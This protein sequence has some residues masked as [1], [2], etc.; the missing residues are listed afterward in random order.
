MRFELTE[1]QR[2]FAASLDRLLAAA[3]TPAVARAW[4]DGDHE[5]GLKLWDRL[6][7]QGVT[8]LA[9]EPVFLAVAFERLG[10][11]AVP[12]PWV[13]S[14]AYLVGREEGIGTVAVPPHVPYALDADVTESRRCRRHA[15]VGRPHPSALRGQ[16]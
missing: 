12:G 7:E 5:S 4:A 14:V 9:D 1:D 11:H 6:A 10:F 15:P 2:D 13:E 8:S 3:D 16:R